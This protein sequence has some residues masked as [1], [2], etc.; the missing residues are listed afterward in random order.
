LSRQGISYTLC[1]MPVGGWLIHGA[2]MDRWNARLGLLSLAAAGILA[3]ALWTPYLTAE[4]PRRALDTRLEAIAAARVRPVPERVELT[5]GDILAEIKR[6][7]FYQE[8]FTSGEDRADILLRNAAAAFIPTVTSRGLPENG[9][10]FYYL[11]PGVYLLTLGGAVW[12]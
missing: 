4:L 1:A 5:R 8:H 7:I 12:L 6:R 11:T 9:W 3:A 2:K 10:F